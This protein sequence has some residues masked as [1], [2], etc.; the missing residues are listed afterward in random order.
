M[1]KWAFCEGGGRWLKRAP[2]KGQSELAG[3]AAQPS[4]HGAIVDPSKGVKAARPRRARDMERM[5]RVV[6]ADW[7][8]AGGSAGEI[9]GELSS[10]ES[11][12]VPTFQGL[13]ELRSVYLECERDTSHSNS[14][15]A[16]VEKGKQ[17]EEK[18]GKER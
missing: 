15:V 5:R 10:F 8:V 4:L 16:L 9:F 6:A 11:E 7:Q 3:L 1:Q 13:T 2:N 12:R 14:D 17:E 18:N